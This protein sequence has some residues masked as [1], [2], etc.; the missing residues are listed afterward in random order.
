MKKIS[1]LSIIACMLSFHWC[2]S[3]NLIANPGFETLLSPVTGEGQIIKA[4][5]WTS[6]GGGT[7][8]L[9]NAAFVGPAPTPCDAVGVPLNFGGYAPALPGS[10]GYAGISIDFINDYYEY[11]Q[12]PLS[13]AMQTGDFYKVEMDILRADSSQYAIN[14]IGVL[15][16]NGPFTQVGTG[17]MS[18]PTQLENAGG[19]VITDSA[20]WTHLL[21]S[22]A[23][24]QATGGENYI[25]IGVFRDFTSLTNF[26]FGNQGAI[27]NNMN[28]R[29]Y[30]Y[31]DNVVVK[32]L[33]ELVAITTD[34]TVLCPNNSTVLTS[35]SNVPFWWSSQANPTDTLS[36]SI[37]YVV[38]PGSTTT[39]YLNGQTLIDSITIY[40]VPPPFV[41]LGPDT[42]FC[43][44]D[45]VVLN[46]YAPDAILYTW[47][48]G[49][50][51]ST[52]L[53]TDTG[54]YWVIV[55]N[56]GCGVY[57]TIHFQTL[58]PNPPVDLG[59]DSTYC[60][61]DKD[62]LYLD[63][64]SNAVSYSWIPFGDTTQ[65]IKVLQPAYYRVTVTHANGC[66]RRAGFEV[67]EICEPK[68]F[69]PSAFTPDGDGLNDVFL[70]SV[71]NLTQYS[72]QV[73][74]RFGQ[75]LFSSGNPS[76]GWDGKYNGKEAPVGI[77]TYRLYYGGY[78][79]EGE[80]THGKYLKTF[81]LIR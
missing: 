3:Q 50:T 76:E 38:A 81:M 42:S 46:A 52:T 24:Y 56:I 72:L 33:N 15:L 5:P 64:G 11:L 13:I 26:D 39:Y 59:L 48:T 79:A 63:A 2:F 23:V 60:F 66:K 8:D 35:N 12:I 6:A 62:T 77:Y 18:F 14:R 70:P 78:D 80:K 9:F 67:L 10:N 53:A 75:L 57:D 25:T 34:D 74:N 69:V 55:D 61:F 28:N 40:V 36:T 73:Y 32:P 54:T 51:T 47:S 27:C 65:V 17:V 31:I 41:D 1:L 16:S 19:T 71:N 37:D 22:P 45:T 44:A 49:D 68:I 7:P 58:L 43:E 21:F 4:S 29:V 20:N 30:Y